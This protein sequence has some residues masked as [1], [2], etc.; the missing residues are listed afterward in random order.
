MVNSH[1]SLE[2]YSTV[3]HYHVQGRNNTL[4]HSLPSNIVVRNEPTRP[5]RSPTSQS[6]QDDVKTYTMYGTYRWYLHLKHDAKETSTGMWFTHCMACFSL[7]WLQT[8][9]DEAGASCSFR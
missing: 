6:I 9:R 1:S 8:P 4:I 2:L 5:S 3:Q 7:R